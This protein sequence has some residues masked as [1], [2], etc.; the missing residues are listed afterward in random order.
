MRLQQHFLP[1]NVN[2]LALGGD[3]FGNFSEET[4]PRDVTGDQLRC[5]KPG[6]WTGSKRQRCRHSG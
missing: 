4:V 2:F 5:G 3:S 1:K 6:R